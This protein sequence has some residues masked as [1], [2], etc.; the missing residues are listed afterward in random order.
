MTSF[1][2]ILAIAALIGCT[3]TAA[4]QQQMP[5]KG[6]IT[7][8][9]G[10]PVVGATIYL[11]KINRYSQTDENG[12]FLIKALP[13]GDY[14]V[15]VSSVEIHKKAIVHHHSPKNLYLAM[16]VKPATVEV[17]EALVT[18]ESARCQLQTSGFAVDVVETQKFALQSTQTTELLD[19]TS[20]VRI[21]QDGGLGSRNRMSINGFSDEAIKVFIDGV[22]ARNYGSSFS[23]SSIPPALIERIEVYKGVVPGHL[24]EDALGGAINVVLKQRKEKSLM[25]SYSIGSF[26]THQWNA[27]G[28]YRTASG[29]LFDASAFYN[30]SDNNY[31]VWGKDVYFRDYLG[32]ITPSNGQRM[33]RFNDGYR[34]LGAKVGF[35]IVDRPW[36][37][38]LMLNAIY[39]NDYKELQQGNTMEIVYGN[40]HYHRNNLALSLNYDK[41]NLLPG[42]DLRAELGMTHLRRTNVDTVGIM[43]GWDGPIRDPQGGFVTYKSGAEASSRKTL[44]V[45][46][47]RTLMA[48]ANATYHLA[49]NH[50]LHIGYLFND[51]VRKNSDAYLTAVE[52]QLR[53]TR[54]LRKQA[55]TATYENA[56][57]DGR[58]RTSLFYKHYFQRVAFHEPFYNETAKQYEVRNTIQNVSQGGYG[59]TLAYSL[60]PQLTLLASAERTLRLPSENELFGNPIENVNASPTLRPETSRN[61]NLGADFKYQVGQHRFGL[62]VMGYL[63]DTRDMIREV[64]GQ[65]DAF[66]SFQNLEDVITRGIDAEL[67]YQYGEAFH[68]RAN[69]SRFDI[70]FNTEFDANGHRYN[71]YRTQIPNEPSLKANVNAAYT[72]RNLL[73]RDSRITIHGNWGYVR[74][75]LLHWS[76]VGSANL[77]TIPTQSPVDL[78]L[79]YFF[80]R[81]KVALNF[82]VKNIADAQIFDNFGLQ[83]PGRSFHL[84][85]TY[86]I[87]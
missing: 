56:L 8:E 14:D 54:D 21:R 33:R 70:L 55:L 37:D 1:R 68:L 12:R 53:D 77:K 2:R 72:L 41:R 23:L 45:N 13:Q 65:R 62:N 61:L 10:T 7:L 36:A 17:A 48:R 71:Y 20:G 35:G 80:P 74:Q 79:T 86:F 15:V 58:L 59:L 76:N 18:G 25:T 87:F 44:G 78:G 67:T 42:L 40:R 19:R 63:R 4:A 60:L 6:Q 5:L 34:S 85:A 69:L 26:N 73:Q 81:N 51:F 66:S 49:D 11:P 46:Q 16:A 39:S 3:L 9:D 47:N 83:K 84:K 50:H 29:L 30:Y 38:R 22:P 57:F 27:A 43:Y 82:D 32:V 31:E 24:A 75:F 52:Q 28:S 64:F